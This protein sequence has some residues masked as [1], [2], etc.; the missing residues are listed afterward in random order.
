MHMQRC[1]CHLKAHCERKAD[2][3]TLHKAAIA[4]IAEGKLASR[5]GA[6]QDDQDVLEPE[7]E[8]Q[9]S[10]RAAKGLQTCC[11]GRMIVDAR[12]VHVVELKLGQ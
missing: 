2:C 5:F 9:Y 11:A 4:E 1:A 8:P 7:A 12:D 10:S 3:A 6:L